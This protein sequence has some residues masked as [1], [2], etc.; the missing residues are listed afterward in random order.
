MDAL[1][2]VQQSKNKHHYIYSAAS[3]VNHKKT[4]TLLFPRQAHPKNL[5]V[6]QAVCK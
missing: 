1:L 3:T 2:E 4:H 6:L 5:F